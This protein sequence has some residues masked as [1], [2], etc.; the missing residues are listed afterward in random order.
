MSE[1]FWEDALG[2]LDGAMLE[3]H[4]RKKESLFLG[5]KQKIF[6][7]GGT[8]MNKKPMQNKW[9][10][11]ILIAALVVMAAVVV[12]I[13]AGSAPQPPVVEAPLTEGLETGVYYYD[14][15]EGEV[16][17]SLH[18]G[19]KFTIAGPGYNKSGEYVVDG[20]AISFDFFREED[21]SAVAK[22]SDNILAF[23]QN[24]TTTEYLK[25]IPYTVS[26]QVAG[27]SQIEAITVINGKTI[28]APADPQ[29][30]GNVFLGWYV[31][32]AFT[33]PYN[34][35]SS[36][37][38]KDT[39]LYAKWAE[40]VAG[41]KE[42]VLTFETGEGIF[43]ME[44]ICTIGG[45]LVFAADYTPPVREGYTFAGWY[46]SVFENGEKL[47]YEAVE[48]TVFTADTTLFAVWTENN[49]GLAAP[50]VSIYENT[51][52]WEGVKDVNVAYTL[53]IT[54]LADDTVLFH[55]GVSGVAKNFDFAME[56]PGEYK[57]ELTASK[58]SETA[59]TVRYYHNK[60]L[61]RVYQFDVIDGKILVFGA[62]E[63]AQKYL[64]TVDCG[65]P[66]HNHANIDNGT[67]TVFNFA[68]CPMQKNGITFI[69]TARAEGYA[70]SV[71]QTFTYVKNLDSVG[72]ITY[73]E[74]TGAFTWS[75][76]DYAAKY[77]VTLTVDGNSYTFDN[78]G[79]TSFSVT[80]YTGQI[81]VSVIPATEGYNSPEGCE[82]TITKTRMPAPQNVAINNLTLSWDAVAHAAS[83]IVKI[84]EKNFSTSETS[85]LLSDENIQLTA[86][87]IYEI[88][89]TAVSNEPGMEASFQS[90][91]VTGRYL[92]MRETVRYSGNTVFW[93]P[94]IGSEA[95]EVQINDG[96]P[97]LVEN[98]TCLK[99]KLTK[100]GKNVIRVRMAGV[101][102]AS[103]A[104]TEV[105][106]YTVKYI[107]RSLDYGDVTEYVAIGDRMELPG[108]YTMVGFNFTGWY[109]APA[110]ANGNGA[111]YIETVFSGNG[112]L[113]LYAN[114]TPKQYNITIYV[115][116]TVTNLIDQSIMQ[117]TY[118]KEF[119][120][121]PA[122]SSDATRGG[123]AGWYTLPGGAGEQLTDAEGNGLVPY[124]YTGD[125]V[126]YPFF[127]TG[128][129]AYV[130]KEDGSFAAQKGP[131]INN[132]TTVR[133]PTT[134][135]GIPITSIMDNAF[136]SCKNMVSI[137]I[138][139]T[140]T[141]VGI[142]S[143][144]GCNG[145]TNITVYAVEGNTAEKF[146]SSHDGALIFYDAPSSSYYLELF[147]RAK[148]G[149]YT[150]PEIVDIIRPNAFMY[151]HIEHLVI[152]KEVTYI[153]EKAFNNCEGL[154]TLTFEPGGTDALTIA[155]HAF[156]N[157]GVLETIT[158]PA[159][160]SQFNYRQL[161]ACVGL[162]TINVETG[163]ASYATVSGMLTNATGDTILLCPA[164]YNQT[165]A[166][167]VGITA[168]GEGAF[169]NLLVSGT[170]VIPA[171][172]Q[173]I[174]KNAFA[175]CAG[176]TE[177]VV[178]G[179]RN[180]PLTIGESAFANCESLAAV[181]FAG[182]TTGVLDTGAVIIGKLAF[183][184]NRSLSVLTVNAGANVQQI[185]E[186]AFAFNGALKELRF[187][188]G[189]AITEI[190]AYAF[191]DATALR[192]LVIHPSTARVDNYAFSGCSAM[193][194]LTFAPNGK[195]INLGDFVFSGCS[196]L[197]KVILP[198]NVESL[199][200]S[201]FDGCDAIREIVVDPA[202]KHLK[203]LDG[204]LYDF[205][206]KV[207]KFY[208][209]GKDGDLTKLPWDTLTHIEDTVFRNNPKIT[210]VNIGA[211]IVAIG[212]SAFENCINLS[213]VTF[214]SG[215]S[216]LAI[217]VSAFENCAALRQISLPDGTDTI[218]EKAFYMSELQSLSIPASVTTIGKYAFAYTKIAELT[219]TSSLTNVGDG[220]FA[221]CTMLENVTIETSGNPLVLG[222]VD[223][224]VPEAGV[225]THTAIKQ[226][227]IPDRVTAI[228][229]YAFADVATLKN[230]VVSNSAELKSIGAYAFADTALTAFNNPEKL[231][232]IGD[233]AFYN[234]KLTSVYIPA[235]VTVIGK[236]AYA[237]TGVAS[238]EFAMGGTAML[239]IKDYAFANSAFTAITFPVRLTTLAS[240]QAISGTT[241]AKTK[242]MPGVFTLFDGNSV[243]NAI[244]V[245][246]GIGTFASK[247]GILYIQGQDTTYNELLYCPVGK[248]GTVIVPKTVTL[249]RSHAFY[250]TGVTHV[251]FEEFDKTDE[252]YGKQLLT[253][254]EQD[255][256]AGLSTA[257]SFHGAALTSITFP[258]HLAV[259]G[260][261][262]VYSGV[263]YTALTTIVFNPDST[264]A[265]K[266]YALQYN[267]SL[268][269]VALP[270]VSAFGQRVFWNN[271]SLT[272]VTF[273]EGST[274]TSIGDYAFCNCTALESISIPKSVQS[275]GKYAFQAS[276]LKNINFPEDSELTSIGL[277]AFQNTALETFTF[278]KLVAT[279]GNR[280]FDGC[281]SLKEITISEKMTAVMDATQN[282]FGNCP[283]L[284]KVNVPEA[285]TSLTSV[286]GVV[287]DL[288][289]STVMYYPQAKNTEGYVMPESIKR[290][291]AHAFRYFVGENVV[292]SP[293]VT[294]IDKYAF[295]ESKIKTITLPKALQKLDTY[296][297]Y[298]CS[299]L[300]TV[301]FEKDCA[302]TSIGQNCFNACIALKSIDLPDNLATM[303][304][305]SFT[306]CT[307]LETVTLPAALKVI[308][309]TCFSQCA[310][311]QRIELQEGIT[312][313]SSSAF[314]TSGLVEIN[315]PTTVT[316]IDANAF[317]S[318]ANLT[319]ITFAPFSQ[320]T[321]LGNYA[322]SNNGLVSITLPD[323]V[324]TLGT[325]LFTRSAKL[326][327]V[328]LGDGI[329][330]IPKNTFMNCL[331]LK[332]V[333]LPDGLTIIDDSAFAACAKLQHIVIP[334]N[335]T[336][337][338]KQA[339]DG[340]AELASVTFLGN[341]LTS[342][343]AA[344]DTDS[345][346]FRGTAALQTI[347]IP[348][349]VK[350]IAKSAFENSGLVSI[351]LPST[352]EEIG[353]SAFKNCV[354]LLEVNIPGSAKTIHKQAFYNCTGM[355]NVNIGFGVENI[356][357][358]AFENCSALESINIPATI[359]SI[360]ANPFISCMNLTSL[361]LDPDNN[362]YQY[363]DG[364]L[365][366]ADMYT[367]IFY[368]PANTAAVF[369]IPETVMKLSDGAFSASQFETF[370][371]PD[372]FQTIPNYLFK[373][374]KNLS[375]VVIPKSVESIG[376]GAF[377]GCTSLKTIDIPYTVMNMG[378]YVF[379]NC[380]AL[381]KVNYEE[382]K[383]NITYGKYAFQNCLALET[384][385]LPDKVT[386]LTE[387]MFKGSGLKHVVIPESI[388]DLS[389]YYVFADCA[390]LTTVDMHENVGNNIGQYF[391]DGC[392]SL[393]S[394]KIP[395]CISTI[396]AYG[397][398]NCTALEELQLSAS[399]E[400]YGNYCFLNCTS[401]KTV[402]FPAEI[403]M[404]IMSHMFDGCTALERVEVQS[405]V[406]LNMYGFAGCTSLKEFI[407][408]SGLSGAMVYNNFFEGCTGFTEFHIYKGQYSSMASEMFKGW[409]EEQTI[410]VHGFAS[411]EEL[412]ALYG[413]AWLDGCD[414]KIVVLPE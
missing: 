84:N 11:A 191:Q 14:T 146:Y 409:T 324:K 15:P 286:D 408:H 171:Y 1:R 291:S 262:A 86:G 298:R 289:M 364:V 128:V 196:R 109:N 110:A 268:T 354:N 276:G 39:V 211:K 267:T 115:D 348:S 134:Y 387:G 4:L 17:L 51:I 53:K 64:I 344:V 186:S 74:T 81:T 129:L 334:A 360:G 100:A 8:D 361:T 219:L 320:L 287:Y 221:F 138:P 48:N 391:F 180:K 26:F 302:L 326:E 106:A 350:F 381:S 376:E 203:S 22:L 373:D 244:H 204:V 46:V 332:S 282:I 27:G 91:V 352:L 238:V 277:M 37:I 32:E 240:P 103:W 31:D 363:I 195:K 335:V 318:C 72:A 193:A 307:K 274:M 281:K 321:T 237:N 23:T 246:E 137:E 10:I 133:I 410:Y 258:S 28:A 49:T 76:V 190:C 347:E 157:C 131:N 101:E 313:I 398:A 251:E 365:Y 66:E 239:E 256:T 99:I 213:S 192:E 254:N 47:T 309:G 95:Y 357:D 311:L 386:A 16:V 407:V 235:G 50:N 356:G 339:F 165:I 120:M 62:V 44:S 132:V 24:G 280:M 167:P 278:P 19:N 177:V 225:F 104:S 55:E 208:P 385:P 140:I 259:M 143:F 370:V 290:I 342:I 314:N 241:G 126:A 310:A 312:T 73:D 261:S 160:V 7:I 263:N 158:L 59:T 40:K 284:E 156:V 253:I 405:L 94:V 400:T 119:F 371:F 380:S 57:I 88:T 322:F 61:D 304:N 377:Y 303:G 155:D 214:D 176:I 374:S 175:G 382:R 30:E 198:A 178:E 229:G 36:V 162:K 54:R 6:F 63:D 83:Y 187:E 150:V 319:T 247:E 21:G 299:D 366:D 80:G 207:I 113:N 273:A 42:Y 399:T 206:L 200:G 301:L 392:T 89:V 173:T 154:K 270:K 252:N 372:R 117:A 58:A 300:E 271:R 210:S 188:D 264:V 144:S 67:S 362:A 390:S 96:E 97:I 288:A 189:A 383:V 139:D 295:A 395:D 43:E 414:A 121:Q 217:G 331:E 378:D 340:C 367:L 275:L 118:T 308:P 145:L 396:N 202:N 71:P 265:F 123:F 142:G 412:I 343:G 9:L 293:N 292:L 233:Y 82:A 212:A 153:A 328:V 45:K 336:R 215:I 107:S 272:S 149:S 231:E 75:A 411:Y 20:N 92:E 222:T 230:V 329:T 346:V 227:T 18:G 359:S 327:N 122:I 205:D 169:E 260:T 201:A 199:K 77:Y 234:S 402:V 136:A 393:K 279:I 111:K 250:E 152:S 33:V 384:L 168:I 245:E 25:K 220:A 56:D 108:A 248:T 125:I 79:K 181:T 151:T 249:V 389:A 355:K 406:M 163:G 105:Y 127:D 413:T 124:G 174:G 148:T 266:D 285:N 70:D 185:G 112:D 341:Q 29:K 330:S 130:L 164:S 12:A 3:Q 35:N 257:A 369:E 166:I 294:Q 224:T 161:S 5:K 172:V 269:S 78:G 305:N 184:N 159:R 345:F 197:T 135:K 183:S 34:F 297:F 223:N 315:I 404:G 401:L 353:Q 351:T 317:T 388:T 216:G 255:F 349:G 116:E 325:N 306:G 323:S 182:N 141:S 68:N 65:D 98:A 179:N 93:D 226:I 13:V 85:F 379:A 52:R 397:F 333:T 296:V 375:T 283:V 90:E 338:G 209:L 2:C 228:G 316:K 38:S 147:P 87:E 243:I 102:D 368:S 69:V 194:S 114:W 403:I 337:M 232:T 41:M 60:A 236:Y 358:F 394:I 170:I 218:G 242:Y